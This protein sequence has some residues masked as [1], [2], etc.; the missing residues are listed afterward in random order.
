MPRRA[1]AWHGLAD[2]SA[3]FPQ[4]V[5]A[6]CRMDGQT[7]GWTRRHA[8]WPHP[9]AAATLGPSRVTR[10]RSF[11]AQ[12]GSRQAPGRGAGAAPA[13]HSPGALVGFCSCMHLPHPNRLPPRP[14]LPPGRVGLVLGS[15]GTPTRRVHHKNSSVTLKAT[16]ERE[17][18]ETRFGR[19]SSVLRTETGGSSR[20]L[21]PACSPKPGRRECGQ[22][23]EVLR[24]WY[25]HRTPE[26]SHCS[27]SSRK[28]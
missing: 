27:R 6:R 15:C 11:A 1:S 5:P 3:S 14:P 21:L 2:R 7:D 4:P 18:G 10:Q 9:G 13:V 20:G 22:P 28:P 16:C 26:T 12:S 24:G 17:A 23:R 8:G 25:R 19:E